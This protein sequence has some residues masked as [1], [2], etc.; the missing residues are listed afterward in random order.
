M[1][2]YLGAVGAET[3]ARRLRQVPDELRGTLRPHLRAAGEAIKTD[4]AAGAGWSTRIPGSLYVQVAFIGRFPGVYVGAR[5]SQAPHARPY[6]GITGE[7]SFRH[8]LNYPN[9]RQ[10]V[11]Q[12]TRPFLRPALLANQGTA[13][14]EVKQAVDDAIRQANV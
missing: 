10:W 13:V 14:R 2:D 11:S 4:A 1:S 6:E 8:P 5:A 9:Q 7:A 12:A 3:L